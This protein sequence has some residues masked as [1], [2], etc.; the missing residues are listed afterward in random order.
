M[1]KVFRRI[2]KRIEHDLLLVNQQ[3]EKGMSVKL[4]IS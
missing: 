2:T 4:G 1:L 3:R